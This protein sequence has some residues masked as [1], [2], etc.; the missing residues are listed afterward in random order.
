MEAGLV[1]PVPGLVLLL[2]Q[3]V[4]PHIGNV[5]G[6]HSTVGMQSGVCFG[7]ET[8]LLT[9]ERLVFLIGTNVSRR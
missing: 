2:L 6:L 4:L 5:L 7:K 1:A 8:N 9:G 3:N